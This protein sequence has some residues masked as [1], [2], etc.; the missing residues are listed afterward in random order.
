M[1]G[2]RHADDEQEERKEEEEKGNEERGEEKQWNLPRVASL[3][4][5]VCYQRLQLDLLFGS[6]Q[7]ER[8]NFSNFDR[9]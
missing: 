6:K 5:K 2:I 4:L 8:A 3:S 9:R 7:T 1:R